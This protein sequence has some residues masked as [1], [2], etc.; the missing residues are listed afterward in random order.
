MKTFV[1]ALALSWLLNGAAM[2][3]AAQPAQT[4]PVG[5]KLTPIVETATTITGQ[6]IRFPQ[7]DNQFTAAL[8]DVAP[9]GQVGRH[10]HP[11]PLFV[12]M[13]EGTL[14]IEMEGHPTHTFSAGQGF[15]EVTNIWH[16]GR[17]LTDK[18]VRFLV[19]F[20]GQKGVPN[21]IRP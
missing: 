8:V 16:N 10:M 2:A 14:S 4:G 13:L 18:P 7:G 3:V 6:P 1:S 19:V 20:S 17:N 11:V 5:L 9:G 21:L 12:Y 15:A